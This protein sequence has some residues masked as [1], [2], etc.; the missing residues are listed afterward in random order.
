MLKSPMIYK[1]F[2]YSWGWHV[3]IPHDLQGFLIQLRLT[4]RNPPWF[5]RGPLLPYEKWAYLQLQ[6]PI[7]KYSYFSLNNDN[8]IKMEKES[9][10]STE[11]QKKKHY[12]ASLRDWSLALISASTL[13]TLAKN[14][15]VTGC[16]VYIRHSKC[17]KKTEI[18]RGMP[19]LKK[20]CHREPCFKYALVNTTLAAL[21]C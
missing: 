9:Q 6:L 14:P 2:W 15:Y 3:E 12:S 5:T 13:R 10:N 7:S 11:K 1:V 16:F 20:H 4:C 17:Q 18:I 8:G 21:V 19:R